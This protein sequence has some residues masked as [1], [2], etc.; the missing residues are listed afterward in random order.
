[1]KIER[2]D[3]ATQHKEK[4]SELFKEHTNK[5]KKKKKKN[6]KN[7]KELKINIIV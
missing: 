3:I 5:K 6:D 2:N 4:I 7:K 1:M